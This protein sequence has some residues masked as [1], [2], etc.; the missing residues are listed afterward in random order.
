MYT[1]TL[2]LNDNLD[3][4]IGIPKAGEPIAEVYSEISRIPM[5]TME[6]QESDEGRHLTAI[7]HGEFMPGQR[8]LGIDDLITAAD[9]KL[10]FKEGVEANKLVLAHIAVGLDR[11]Q[12]GMQRVREAGINISASLTVSK[13]LD[14]YLDG[15]RLE[16]QIYQRIKTYIVS[17]G[18]R[19]D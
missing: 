16:E 19:L 1:D 3:S 9:T 6:K 7:I 12:G 8:V 5:L 4:V 18:T 10:E 13:L 15:G 17:G 14:Y 11:E 2:H